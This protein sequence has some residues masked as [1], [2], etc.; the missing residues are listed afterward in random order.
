MSSTWKLKHAYKT[1]TITMAPR[2]F[3]S[4]SV[5][6]RRKK[7]QSHVLKLSYFIPYGFIARLK[8][9]F[10]YLIK[11]NIK[12]SDDDEDGRKWSRMN[13]SWCTQE[14]FAHLLEIWREKDFWGIHARKNKFDILPLLSLLYA[15]VRSLSA[16]QN[17][18][19]RKLFFFFLFIWL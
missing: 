15:K 6:W 7:F 1:K 14:K 4:C 3:P 2:L 18:S 17:F 19:I 8:T 11:K 16:L 5:E 9:Y 13:H 12:S 10:F